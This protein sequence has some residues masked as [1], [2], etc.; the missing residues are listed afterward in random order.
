MSTTTILGIGAAVI[1]AVALH[2]VIC[3]A[4]PLRRIVAL[5]LLG[6]GIFLLIG[7]AA[8]RGAGAGFESDPVPQALVI[9]GIVVAFAGSS[10]AVAILTRLHAVRN[11]PPATDE[12]GAGDA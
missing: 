2:G 7:V 9:T 8:R 1:I 11:Q 10:L 4:T 6:G 12:S 3:S 5:N